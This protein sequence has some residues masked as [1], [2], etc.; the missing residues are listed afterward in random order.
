MGNLP[1][2]Y[3]FDTVSNRK[4]IQQ[5]NTCNWLYF[6]AGVLSLCWFH[7]L[8]LRSLLPYQNKYE[9]QHES[10]SELHQNLKPHQNFLDFLLVYFLF[11][12]IF[13]DFLQNK[14]FF[15]GIGIWFVAKLI[16]TFSSKD[17]SSS[18]WVS[19][20]VQI[21]SSLRLFWLQSWLHWEQSVN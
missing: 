6:V 18:K 5:L 8:W 19:K 4:P 14:F 1:K 2:R 15:V 9:V 10:S 11:Y 16:S 7:H 12:S 13:N 21:F 20:L 17:R 3:H